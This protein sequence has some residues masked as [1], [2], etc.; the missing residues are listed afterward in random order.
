MVADIPELHR[1]A[2]EA[3]RKVVQHPT[4][5]GGERHPACRRL[6]QAGAIT[7][8]AGLTTAKHC[9]TCLILKCRARCDT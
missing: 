3:V 2:V 7:G 5:E 1:Q 6:W 9:D 4:R 8:R